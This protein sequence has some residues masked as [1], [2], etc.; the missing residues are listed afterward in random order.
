MVY[1][2]FNNMDIMLTDL[3]HA[4][5]VVCVFRLVLTIF[6]KAVYLTFMTI[7]HKA[8]TLL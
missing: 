7:F 8:L 3:A 1:T 5:L 6:N 4:C 2:L